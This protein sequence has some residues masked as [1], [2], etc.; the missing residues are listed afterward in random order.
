MEAVFDPSYRAPLQVLGSKVP[1]HDHEWMS[2]I[3][4]VWEEA[5]QLSSDGYPIGKVDTASTL[6]AVAKL[7]KSLPKSASS[8]PIVYILSGV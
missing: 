6:T 3:R 4:Q 2:K 7:I 8:R 1:R 5:G